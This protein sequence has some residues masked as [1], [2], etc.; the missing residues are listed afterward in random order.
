MLNSDKLQPVQAEHVPLNKVVMSREF[1]SSRGTCC[2]NMC[3]ECPYNP[4][5]TAGTTQKYFFP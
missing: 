5:H 3:R 1:L 4:R 2:G